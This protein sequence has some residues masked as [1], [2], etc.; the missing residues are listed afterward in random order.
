MVDAKGSAIPTTDLT[1][2]EEEFP[3]SVSMVD[4]TGPRIPTLQVTLF[5][6]YTVKS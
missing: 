6:L 2:Q 4:S 5:S 3:W 1:L